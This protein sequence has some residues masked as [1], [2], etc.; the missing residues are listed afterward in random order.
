MTR[1]VTGMQ[2][3]G[4]VGANG[5]AFGIADKDGVESNN[6]EMQCSRMGT[7]VK[8]SSLRCAARVSALPLLQLFTPF[9]SRNPRHIS[10][11]A[12]PGLDF[13]PLSLPAF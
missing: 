13:L 2:A 10:A 12:C 8:L 4:G 5:K 11:F 6:G 1:A 3:W 7:L 9:F